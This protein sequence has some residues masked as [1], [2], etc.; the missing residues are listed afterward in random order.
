MIKGRRRTVVKNKGQGEVNTEEGAEGRGQ[1]HAV[2]RVKR[3]E[4]VSKGRRTVV[5]NTG[6]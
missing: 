1:G 6:K 5:K 3:R 4:K 2:N